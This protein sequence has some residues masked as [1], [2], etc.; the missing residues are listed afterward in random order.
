MEKIQAFVSEQLKT[1]VPK[2]GIGDG[3]RFTL[4]SSRVRRKEP[5]CS[6][7]PL[8]QDMAVASPRPLL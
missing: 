7:V 6:R 1:D 8:L 3:V 5:R 4:R 2:F